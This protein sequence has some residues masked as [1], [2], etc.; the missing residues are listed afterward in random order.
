[1]PKL[2]IANIVKIVKIEIIKQLIMMMDN[3]IKEQKAKKN[4]DYAQLG[5]GQQQDK[6]RQH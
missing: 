4:L 6:K 3:K 1:M 5:S 2:K